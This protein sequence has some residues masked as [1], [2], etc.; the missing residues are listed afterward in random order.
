MVDLAD[1][2]VVVGSYNPTGSVSLDQPETSV[3]ESASIHQ[4]VNTTEFTV[5]RY[6]RL[7]Y[8]QTAPISTAREGT[9]APAYDNATAYVRYD[10]IKNSNDRLYEAIL[11]LTLAAVNRHTQTPVIQD[12][13]DI[14]DLL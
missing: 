10:K 5:D 7:T 1:T 13:G 11:L 4:T 3:A 14:S 2:P 6:G 8:A 9:L 12:L